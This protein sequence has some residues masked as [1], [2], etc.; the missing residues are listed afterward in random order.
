L[1]F[2]ALVDLTLTEEEVEVIKTA[3]KVYKNCAA[4]LMAFTAKELGNDILKKL[5]YGAIF[6]YNSVEILNNNN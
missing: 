1:D 5:P 3:E 6:K 2:E 4:Y